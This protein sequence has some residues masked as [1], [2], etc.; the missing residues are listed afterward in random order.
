M[1]CVLSNLSA[2]K[3]QAI[4]PDK[5]AILNLTRS[6]EKASLNGNE[7]KERLVLLKYRVNIWGQFQGRRK[8]KKVRGGGSSSAEGVSAAR[9]SGDTPPE[10]FPFLTR[11][12]MFFCTFEVISP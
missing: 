10:F 9:E 3:F 1:A 4:C 11:S 5:F 12:S 2:T 8:T 7:R 6:E